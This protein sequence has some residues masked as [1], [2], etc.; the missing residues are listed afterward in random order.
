MI[1][2]TISARKTTPP[3]TPPTIGP[4]TGPGESAFK[5]SKDS[6]DAGELHVTFIVKVIQF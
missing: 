1:M 6:R 5:K 2:A 4:V 3:I